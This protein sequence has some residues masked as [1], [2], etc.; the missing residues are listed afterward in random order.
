MDYDEDDTE[1]M[2]KHQ[3]IADERMKIALP[4]IVVSSLC[5]IGA[6][7]VLIFLIMRASETLDRT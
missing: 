6:V 4:V 5:L 3:K 1:K 7:I 2:K